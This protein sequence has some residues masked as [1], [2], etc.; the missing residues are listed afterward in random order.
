MVRVSDLRRGNY[1][2]LELLL[3]GVLHPLARSVKYSREGAK[4]ERAEGRR[5]GKEQAIA[6]EPSYMPGV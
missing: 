5:Q 2:S 4:K 3:G 6:P 1:Q